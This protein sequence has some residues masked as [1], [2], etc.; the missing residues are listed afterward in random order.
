M[1][2]VNA[3]NRHDVIHQH[4]VGGPGSLALRLREHDT[5]GGHTVTPNL[6]PACHAMPCQ[7]EQSLSILGRAVKVMQDSLKRTSWKEDTL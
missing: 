4:R 3:S 7:K 2:G 6:T 1:L 5:A